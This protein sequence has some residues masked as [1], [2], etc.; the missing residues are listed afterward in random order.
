ME[1][2]LGHLWGDFVCQTDWMALT[3]KKPGAMGWTA[4]LVHALVYTLAVFGVLALFSSKYS[5]QA[6]LVIWIT[7]AIIDHYELVA[8]FIWARNWLSP[9][10]ITKALYIG[11]NSSPSSVWSVRNA[12]WGACKPKQGFH[13]ERPEHLVW[14]IYI[15]IDNTLHLT[16]NYAALRWL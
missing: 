16:I 12:P 6:L 1:Q 3:K 8:K 10:W 7:H 9:R 4:A 13:P 11:G 2:L 15:V 5:W 14:L